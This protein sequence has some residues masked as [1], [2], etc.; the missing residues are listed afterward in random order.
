[1]DEVTRYEHIGTVQAISERFLVP[2]LD[3]LIDA[4]PFEIAGFHADNGSQS[5][6]YR[7]AALP[8]KLH[9][10]QFTKSRA[11][12]CDDNALVEG[13]NGVVIRH[14]L[15]YD[16]IPQ[17][18]AAPVN[19]STRKVLSPSLNDHRPCLFATER[20]DAKG[21]IRRHYRAQDVATPDE[22]LKSL[23]DPA[24]WLEPGVSFEALD[25][26]AHAHSDLDAARKVLAARDALWRTLGRE[27]GCAA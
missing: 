17:R 12:Q 25:A 26:L 19:A 18:L 2:V 21:R 1:M 22:K 27:W 24:R 9:V 8:N 16:P 20:R 10:G 7:A 3:A 13:K 14:S 5:I 6:H 15:G 4:Y 11:R 23:P